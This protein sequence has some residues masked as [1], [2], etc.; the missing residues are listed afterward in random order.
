MGTARAFQTATRLNNGQILVTGGYGSSATKSAELY[1]PATKLWSAAA[2]MKDSRGEHT[3]TLLEDGRVLVVGGDTTGF[4]TLRTAEIYDAT[5]NAWSRTGSMSYARAAHTA[6]LLADGKVLVVGGSSDDDASTTTAEVYDPGTGAFTRV[7]DPHSFHTHDVAAPIS[8]TRV[9]VAGGGEDLRQAEVFDES[10]DSW[11]TVGPLDVGRRQGATATALST[12]RVLVA[13][14]QADSGDPVADAEVF[15]PATNKFSSTSDMNQARYWHEATKLSDGRVLVTGGFGDN[16]D[17][18]SAEIW[19][20]D[21]G[22]W[23]LTGSLIA[24]RDG[25]TATVLSSGDVLVAGGEDQGGV[26]ASSETFDPDA[27]RTHDDKVAPS[28]AWSGNESLVVW[29][30]YR[31]GNADIYATRIDGSGRV[32]DAGGFPV[33]RAPGPQTN[34]S[35]AWNGSTFLV[36]WTDQRS[37]APHIYATRVAENKAVSNPNGVAVS[38]A[39]GEQ[40]LPAVAASGSQFLVVWQDLRNTNVNIYATRVSA[41][42]SVANRSGVAISRAPNKQQRPVVAGSPSGWLVTWDDGRSGGLDIFSTRVSTTGAV[43]DPSGVAVTTAAGEQSSPAVAWNG[44]N[45]I[46]VW[47]DYRSGTSLDVYASRVSP[48]SGAVLNPSAIAVATGPASQ[49]SPTVSTLGTT[50]LVGWRDDSSSSGP[51]IRA[52]RLASSGS[53]LD[54]AARNVVTAAAAQTEP[55]LGVNGT[56]FVAVWTDNRAGD[57]TQIWGGRIISSGTTVDG[58][59]FRVSTAAPK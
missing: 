53:L 22:E 57:T 4:A 41:T 8:G 47:S 50:A 29:E 35:V 9:L 19:N 5:T 3:A 15:N 32:L 45:Y 36:A 33:S 25:H 56:D 59:G 26:L 2:S 52:R 14:G 38:S 27:T 46:V 17:L 28:V 13:G 16:Q 23:Q 34:P 10:S 30:D 43:L 21:T 31:N 49:N 20:P 44:T 1:T 51:D 24:A 6:T 12:G 7:S 42:G 48:S 54:G 40:S 11:T 37:G 18:D 39:T 55:A 58:Q